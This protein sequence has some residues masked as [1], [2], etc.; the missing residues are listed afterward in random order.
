MTGIKPEQIEGYWEALT[1]IS[2]SHVRSITESTAES[3][4]D[5]ST[6][7]FIGI[8]VQQSIFQDGLTRTYGEHSSPRLVAD[9]I[10]GLSKRIKPDSIIDPTCGYGL[11][12]ATAAAAAGSKILRGIEINEEVAERAS[13]IWE[14]Q[15][16][17]IRG[18][19]LQW[20]EK[21]DKKYGMV[22]CDPPINLHLRGEEQEALQKKYKTNDFTS[23]LILASLR[24]LEP[25]GAGVFSVAP[26]FLF[27]KRRER[28]LSS[29]H[30]AGFR[31]SAC[32]QAPSGT[33]HNT[34]IATYLIVF[35]HG[36]QDDIF[37]GQLKDDKTH[38]DHL[39]ANLHRRKP[40]G[41]LSLGRLCSLSSFQG[42]E[43]FAAR[44][45]LER[46]AR[47]WRWLPHK[48]SNIISGY[49]VSRAGRPP[50]EQSL[51]DDASSLYLRLIGT[52]R[53]SRQ[54]EEFAKSSE[55][56]HIKFNTNIVDPAFMEYWVNESRIGRLTLASA[57]SGMVVPRTSLASL[58]D[59]TIYLP[60][61]DQQQYVCESWSY[62][63]RVRS[64]A[65]ELESSLSAWSDPP[66]Q[67]LSRIKAINQEDRY[68]DWLESLPFPLASILWRHHAAK[69]SYR[70]QY[71]VLLHF[72]EATA[73]FIATIHLSAY[74]SNESEWARIASDLSSKLSHQGLSLERAT[75]GAW[76]L[77]VERLASA[78][79]S[80]LKK[81]NE[82]ED[83]AKI[84]EQMYGTNDRQVLDMLSHKKLLHVLQSANKIR[85]DNLGHA[86]AIGEDA[87]RRIHEDLLDL[88]FQ[89]RSIF[90]RRWNRYELLQ[91]GAIRY[92]AG[93]YH[94][95]CK[96]IIGTRSAP[97]E[98]REYE[99]SIP[100][101]TDCLHLFDSASRT[102]LKLQP[103]VEVIPSPERQALACFIF[104]RV[105]KDG[106]RWVSYHFDQESEITHP[107]SG[108]LSALSR[109][110]RF[111]PPGASQ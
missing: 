29:L 94:I 49:A 31:I 4:L 82:N 50:K 111:N 95:N 101:E 71:Q 66:D 80:T 96:R 42:Y 62:L 37:I 57:Q 13:Q 6:K 104:N 33:R 26:S 3:D 86:G 69:D 98:E 7:R 39:L 61:K 5:S 24:V 48:G 43:G 10:A 30:E 28:F 58:L 38:L 105:D 99:S 12:L 18:E 16:N 75:F 20:L 23:A 73:A 40:K 88:V 11:L 1:N 51:E 85:N 14:S 67:I 102:G 109:L 19:A 55:V 22:V 76:K 27:D 64:E 59:S 8:L 53:A 108:V 97:F 15:I 45:Q 9:F 93:T 103:F 41:D 91:P 77:V 72:F 84:L 2:S 89:L 74:M 106:A 63:Q 110:N 79:A 21:D 107:S 34:S 44:E 68:E 87:A 81:S 54:F 52:P 100:L 65:D 36:T 92:K 46:L 47:D 83:D 56:A 17:V 60:P 90:G 32:I 70:E 25:G 78:S 35:D